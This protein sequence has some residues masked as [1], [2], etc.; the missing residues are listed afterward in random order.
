MGHDSASVFY[1]VPVKQT[2]SSTEDFI[3]I[4][5]LHLNYL[6]FVFKASGLCLMF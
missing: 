6:R 4:N 2:Q 5:S 3:T 1:P